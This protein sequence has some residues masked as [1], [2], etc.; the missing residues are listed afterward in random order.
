MLREY[1][2][3]TSR[4][5]SCDYNFIENEFILFGFKKKIGKK[6]KLYYYIFFCL[7]KKFF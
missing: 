6:H 4:I 5:L 7:V 2:N 3:I 1:L